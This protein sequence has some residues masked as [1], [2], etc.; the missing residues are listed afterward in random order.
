MSDPF[1]HLPYRPCVGIVLQNRDGKVFTGERFGTPGAWQMPQ[2]GVDEGEDPQDAAFRELF[3]ETHVSADKATLRAETRDWLPYELPRDLIPKLWNGKY[4]GQKQKW[5]LFS[6]QGE[7][8]D[9]DIAAIDEEFRA[10]HWM[11]IDAL[12]A[13]IVPFKRDVYSAVFEEFKELT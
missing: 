11:E 2:G 8:S 6:F 7:D 5:F 4:R 3:E 13:Q 1:A 9:I 12:M 10:W